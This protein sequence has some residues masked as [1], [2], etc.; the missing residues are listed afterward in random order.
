MSRIKAQPLPRPTGRCNPA[1]GALTAEGAAL[2]R[3]TGASLRRLGRTATSSRVQLHHRYHLPTIATGA[4]MESRN[5]RQGC[6]GVSRPKAR[7]EDTGERLQP[8][9]GGYELWSGELQSQPRR[10]KSCDRNWSVLRKPR[11]TAAA[12]PA[13]HD[14]KLSFRGL[15]AVG[16]R[17]WE[18]AGMAGAGDTRARMSS[19]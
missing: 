15:A 4:L 14:R 9:G 10:L 19:F 8:T 1:L 12:L 17:L 13:P 11:P 3:K 6:T 7:A 2:P 18:A 16:G 5:H